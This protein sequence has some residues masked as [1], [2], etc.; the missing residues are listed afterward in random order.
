M[1]QKQ[2]YCSYYQAHVNRQQAWFFVA[3][4]RSFENMM[5]DRTLD[6]EQ[7]IFEFFVPPD[8][9]VDFLKI[10]TLLEKLGVVAQVQKLDNRLSLPGELVS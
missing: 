9:E 10:I 8:T 2:N 5:F 1:Q 7:S 4:V 3:V 6:T